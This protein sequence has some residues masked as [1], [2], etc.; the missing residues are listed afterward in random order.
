[1]LPRETAWGLRL[2]TCDAQ[3]SAPRKTAGRNDQVP[4]THNER[5]G[6]DTTIKY[7]LGAAGIALGATI[8]YLQRSTSGA[9]GNGLCTTI[10]Y[11]RG[12]AGIGLG[13][14][15]KYLRRIASA[16]VGSGLGTTMKFFVNQDAGAGKKLGQGPMQGS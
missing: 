1:V 9:A 3:R 2:S 8:K 11:L 6:L 15:I 10:K 5:I 13:T 14:M 7:L 16:A 12:A 4:T